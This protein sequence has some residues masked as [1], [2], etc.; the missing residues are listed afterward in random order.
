MAPEI[1]K[2]SMRYNEKV[3][4]WACGVMTYFMLSGDYPFLGNDKP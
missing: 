3:D 2:A 1:V 4:V